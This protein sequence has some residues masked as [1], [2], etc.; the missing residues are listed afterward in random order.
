MNRLYNFISTRVFETKVSG[1][2]VANMCRGAAK[3]SKDR[4]D[5]TKYL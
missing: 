5:R 4:D 1:K 3:V 2:M